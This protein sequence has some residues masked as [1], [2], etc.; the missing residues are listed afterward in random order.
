[1][2]PK[3]ISS[4]KQLKQI[5]TAAAAAASIGLSMPLASHAIDPYPFR[6]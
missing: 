3:G 5:I 6:G 4:M 1:M 2:Q